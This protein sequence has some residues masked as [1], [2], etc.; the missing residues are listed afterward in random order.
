MYLM[1]LVV[2][3]DL[4]NCKLIFIAY[5]IFHNTVNCTL[6]CILLQI[7]AKH[8]V[9]EMAIDESRYKLLNVMQEIL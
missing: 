7:E 6:N 8:L 5:S 4:E 1:H 2:G 3:Y 9:D